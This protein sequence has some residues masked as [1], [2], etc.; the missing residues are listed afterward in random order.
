MD[1]W[2]V[3]EMGFNTDEPCD[4]PAFDVSPKYIMD[5]ITLLPQKFRGEVEWEV[6]SSEL[7]LLVH[8]GT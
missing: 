8:V 5:F 4:I 2:E 3:R 1:R 7:K 6:R